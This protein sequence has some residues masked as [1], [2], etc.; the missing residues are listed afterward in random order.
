MTRTVVPSSEWC[1]CPLHQHPAWTCLGVVPSL[2]E[3]LCYYQPAIGTVR[4]DARLGLGHCHLH[5]GSLHVYCS[6]GFTSNFPLTEAPLPCG[7][8]PS[9]CAGSVHFRCIVKCF[10]PPLPLMLSGWLPR[11]RLALCALSC[12]CG[13]LSK[14]SLLAYVLVRSV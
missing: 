11:Q 12:A 2:Q 5:N 8:V 9:P 7:Y 10:A 6:D 14:W 4:V 13:Q 3:C 1:A